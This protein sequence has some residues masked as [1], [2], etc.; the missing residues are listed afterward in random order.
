MGRPGPGAKKNG[1]TTP[2]R[3]SS[4]NKSSVG[5]G[6]VGVPSPKTWSA[7]AVAAADALTSVAR[8]VLSGSDDS[9][10]DEEQ[11]NIRSAIPEFVS[12]EVDVVRMTG[13]KKFVLKILFVIS[14]T[15]L[16]V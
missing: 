3:M 1:S 16:M 7:E 6:M 2:L 14:L 15:F 10:I 4:L 9:R 11:L 12:E 13:G 5:A 8:R